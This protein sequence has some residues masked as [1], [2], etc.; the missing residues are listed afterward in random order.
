MGV[1]ILADSA[2]AIYYYNII[3]EKY[4]DLHDKVRTNEN[5]ER[6]YLSS[7]AVACSCLESKGLALHNIIPFVSF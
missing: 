4:W 3:H 2:R 6:D 1:K 5:S 7:T